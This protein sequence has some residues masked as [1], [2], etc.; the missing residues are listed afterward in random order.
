M[1][2]LKKGKKSASSLPSPEEVMD[3]VCNKDYDEPV[4]IP[5]EE[6]ED[7]EEIKLVEETEEEEVEV[8]APLKSSSSAS[9]LGKRAKSVGGGKTELFDPTKEVSNAHEYFRDN[10]FESIPQAL[11][12]LIKGY[13][14]IPKKKY[15]QIY[16]AFGYVTVG[17]ESRK[18]SLMTSIN[19]LGGS[20]E[21][22]KVTKDRYVHHLQELRKAA[23]MVRS[24]DHKFTTVIQVDSD[25]GTFTCK[26][27][28]IFS[29]ASPSQIVVDGETDLR[30]LHVNGSV[31]LK[32]G[33]TK[34]TITGEITC[35][36]VPISSKVLYGQEIILPGL[37]DDVH[38]GYGTSS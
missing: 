6:Q 10:Y 7:S 26:G 37:L 15:Q 29:C 28:N 22:L 4:V 30:K 31:A 38:E 11:Y 12:N 35:F 21:E 34:K 13:K 23:K 33:K 18:D 32:T 27:K 25:R 9:I 20:F 36:L 1:P 14:K 24:T 5:T 19:Q 3:A 16:L 17:S 8:P 2:K